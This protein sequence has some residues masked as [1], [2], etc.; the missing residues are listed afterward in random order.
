MTRFFRIR[1]WSLQAIL[2]VSI[3]AAVVLSAAISTTLSIRREQ[4]S[5]RSEL[6][7][8]ADV[9]LD[10]LFVSAGDRLYSLD[11]PAL[12]ALTRQLGENDVVLA[13]QIY[14]A[15]GE[16]VT[17]T[18]QS[19]ADANFGHQLMTTDETLY[20]WSEG[21]LLAG[22]SVKAGPQRFG[23][24]S[25]ELS[26]A[27]L[28]TKANAARVQGIASG[29]AVGVIGVLL[30]WLL[31]RLITGPVKSLTAAAQRLANG[32]DVQIDD[33]AG[34]A[35]I[36]ALAEAFRRMALTIQQRETEA[37]TL[38]ASLLHT[39]GQLEATVGELKTSMQA[40]DQL[41]AIVRGLS[42]PV[43]PV[44]EGV[45]VMP[46]IGVIDS[47]RAEV[48]LSS[49]L[50]AVEQQHPHT[51]ILDLTG[52][53]IIDSEVAN[54]VLRAVMATRL[55]GTETLLVGLR[56]DLAE[57]IVALGVD[58]QDIVTRSDL[59]HGIAYALQRQR[60]RA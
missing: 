54:V 16:I 26:T 55:L 38:N 2:A 17:S 37:S 33:G 23:A 29:L 60:R 11:K 42:S 53:A 5:F 9:V 8:R 10:V 39:V 41:S 52:V 59:Q 56:P 50:R 14:D 45:L 21:R 46:L 49:L 51:A 25:V 24:F 12:V 4:E 19:S 32:E 36:V 30:A 27:T 58:T 28:E 7:D 40:R 22:R 15:H 6:Q 18:D 1:Q 43:I 35:E 48:V 20:V 47:E 57:T 3:I 34:S 44:L 31:S 13:A